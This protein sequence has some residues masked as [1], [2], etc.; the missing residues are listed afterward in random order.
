MI[1]ARI[2]EYELEWKLLSL[3]SP[4]MG[5]VSAK[6]DGWESR[7]P[8]RYLVVRGETSSFLFIP[9]YHQ[10]Q[11]K[12]HQYKYKYPV[13]TTLQTKETENLAMTT[14]PFQEGFIDDETARDNAPH[15]QSHEFL[16][17]GRPPNIGQRIQTYVS[18]PSRFE[19]PWCRFGG[20]VTEVGAEPT[21]EEWMASSFW[22][23]ECCPDAT[24]GESTFYVFID[25][26]PKCENEPACWNC[27]ILGGPENNDKEWTVSELKNR[28]KAVMGALHGQEITA[29]SYLKFYGDPYQLE[30][31]APYAIG[32]IYKICLKL[33]DGKV[34]SW[35]ITSVEDVTDSVPIENL[36]SSFK[37]WDA[38]REQGMV[39]PF[40]QSP[41]ERK[42]HALEI[43]EFILSLKQMYDDSE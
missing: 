11:P 37:N 5:S 24:S 23:T 32:R 6:L 14:L 15:E 28:C 22:A 3:K 8:T 17:T 29:F 42:K 31:V 34:R 7:V 2:Y 9:T 10:T 18:L 40:D 12:R 13:T 21:M 25:E 43:Q 38:G 1:P 19:F 30:G 41:L 27:K 35:R 26:C 16:I 39:A 20:I 33:D 4:P 36:P